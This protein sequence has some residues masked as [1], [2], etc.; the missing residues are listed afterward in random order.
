MSKLLGWVGWWQGAL[1]GG[2][3]QGRTNLTP[4][5]DLH[6]REAPRKTIRRVGFQS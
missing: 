4:E 1:S 3:G 6:P 5:H 2:G